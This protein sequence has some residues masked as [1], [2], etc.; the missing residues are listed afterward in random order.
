MHSV[1]TAAFTA[2]LPS[3][4]VNDLCVEI[5]NSLYNTAKSSRK[6]TVSQQRTP[7]VLCAQDRWQFLLQNGDAKDIWKSIG[8]SGT[9][10]QST[11][12]QPTPQEFCQH[13]AHLLNP[14]PVDQDLE[15]FEPSVFKYIPST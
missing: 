7:Q 2:N 3:T 1:D 10:Q 6:P 15:H 4:D 5:S 9:L 12:D 8:W 14:F 11:G 13:Y